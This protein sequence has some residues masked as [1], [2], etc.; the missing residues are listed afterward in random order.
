MSNYLFLQGQDPFNETRASQQYQLAQQLCEAGHNVT[1]LLVQNGVTP[2]RRG[3]ESKAFDALLRSGVNV[4]ADDF[5]L[6]QR[7]IDSETLKPGVTE[8][9]IGVAIDAMLAG[10]KVIW[11]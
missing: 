2:A 1:L 11:H 5:S 4:L 3:A 8:T 7:N 9:D 6:Q 10:H